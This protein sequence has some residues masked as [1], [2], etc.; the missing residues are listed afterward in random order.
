MKTAEKKEKYINLI[1]KAIE[2]ALSQECLI[3]F[4][5]SILE[6][7]FNKTSDI[8]VA[9][10]C[11]RDLTTKDWFKLEE[12]LE[13]IPTLRDIDVVDIRKVKNVNFLENIL[14][15]KIWKSSPDL[16]KDLKKHVE[17]LK[18]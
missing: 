12:I 3:I 2:K 5:G 6:D 9:V 15:G 16:L 7:R 1:G 8:D 4:F 14:K 10:F 17:N 11:K 13:K 18:K